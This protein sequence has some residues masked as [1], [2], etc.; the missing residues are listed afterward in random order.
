MDK[1]V[2]TTSHDLT[3]LSNNKKYEC[4]YDGC[5]RTYTSMG[6][7]K[8]HLKAHEGRFDYKCDHDGCDKAFLS[9]YSLK[10]HRRI[11]TGEKPYSCES[12]GCDKSFNT[13]YR[14]NAHKRVHTGEL[15]DCEFD[16]CPKQFTTKSDLR[17]HTRTHTGEKPYQCKVDGCGKA[18]KASHHLRSHSGTHQNEDMQD[19]SEFKPGV[20]SA[21]SPVEVSPDRDASPTEDYSTTPKSI[22]TQSE[23]SDVLSSIT[24]SPGAQQILEGLYREST[25]W[26]STL[27]G[28]P[29][30]S[31][32]MVESTQPTLAPSL[33]TPS[34]VATSLPSVSSAEP[35]MESSPPQPLS[36]PLQHPPH[37]F[38]NTSLPPTPSSSSPSSSAPVTHPMLPAPAPS[39][40]PEIAHALQ[41]LHLL[42][43]T[44][45]LQNLLAISQLPNPWSGTHSSLSH[46]ISAST[47]AISQPSTTAGL[48]HQEP[49]VAMGGVMDPSYNQN[50]PVFPSM[51][52]PSSSSVMINQP[53]LQMDTSPPGQPLGQTSSVSHTYPLSAPMNYN[54]GPPVMDL[55]SSSNTHTDTFGMPH[56]SMMDEFDCLD[57]GTQTLPVDLD[58]LLAASYVPE[59]SVNPSHI[60]S[61]TG[62]HMSPPHD[63][64]TPPLAHHSLSHLDIS[65]S[66]APSQLPQT[67]SSSKVDQACQTDASISTTCSVDS[68]CCKVSVKKECACCGCCSCECLPCT[69]KSDE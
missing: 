58:S 69:K 65:M 53:L 30:T 3:E 7:L 34:P 37:M 9:S 10:V 1:E 64:L 24:H 41:T 18:F 20:S 17:K 12:D 44:G 29:A 46:S 42:S 61:S 56:S 38:D 54:Y 40:T 49:S 59:K 13:L 57:H 50:A 4:V 25:Q 14:L 16:S 6:N 32:G 51:G 68:S 43:K 35:M 2:F 48:Q 22:P 31:T 19:K 11:H 36:V 21:E 66:T 28:S 15:F 47:P 55:Q 63:L 39:F 5:S 27:V 62:I 45:A 67:T 23:W 33:G 60:H 8:T 26:L 52:G